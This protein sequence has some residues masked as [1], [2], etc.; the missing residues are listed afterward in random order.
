MQLS[1]LQYFC[2][3]Y[4]NRSISKAAQQLFV[5]QPTISI[6][7]KKLEEELNNLLFIRINNCIIPTEEGTIFFLQA[8][9]ILRQVETAKQ[10]MI[11]ISRQETTIRLGIPYITA[12]YLIPKFRR[13]EREFHKKHP[14]IHLK[15][16]EENPESIADM[17]RSKQLDLAVDAFKD[18]YFADFNGMILCE[19]QIY[20]CVNKQHPLASKELITPDMLIGETIATNYSE[21]AF[22][23]RKIKQWFHKAGYLPPQQMYLNQA[24]TLLRLLSIN[25]VVALLR[26]KML[27]IGKNIVCIPLKD[28]IYI[29]LS[30][31]W[32]HQKHM[33]SKIA[34]LLESLNWFKYTS[35][36]GSKTVK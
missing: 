36:D 16:S 6:A 12:I 2:A 27:N 21:K 35:F 19:H 4:I 29:Q 11:N 33:Q 17:L 22:P 5:S 20:L 9:E 7:I 1:Q 25:E 28:P 15:I 10:N 26:P 30:I 3:T 13:F 8:Q 32:C 34:I 18:P 24:S 23:N 31:H 14:E